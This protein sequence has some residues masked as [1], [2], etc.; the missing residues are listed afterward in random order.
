MVASGDD[1]SAFAIDILNI[2]L[3]LL[4]LGAVIYL[5]ISFM[6]IRKKINAIKDKK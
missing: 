5:L 2:V 4:C 6:D 1:G 3:V